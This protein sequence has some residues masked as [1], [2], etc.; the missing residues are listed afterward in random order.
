MLQSPPEKSTIVRSPKSLR[1]ARAALQAAYLVS[2]GLGVSL[3]ERMFTSPRRY[4]RPQREK[5]TLAT[6]RPFSVEV[7]LRSPR[8]GDRT[9]DVAAWRWGLGPTVLLVHGWEGRGSQLG[10]FVHPLVAAGMSVVAFDLP[11]HGDSPGGRTYLT[12]MAD[13]V[14]DVAASIGPIHATIAHSFGAAAVLLAHGRGHLDV[15][16]NVMIA[17]NALL[18]DSVRRFARFVGLDD[19][20]GAG[21]IAQLGASTGVPLATLAIDQLAAHRDA[22]LLVIHDRDDGEVPLAHGEALAATWPGARLRVTEGLGHRR[23][24]RDPDVIAEVVADLRR[25]VP[26]PPSDLVREVD[27]VLLVA[28]GLRPV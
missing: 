20:D 8:W 11:G 15:G 16:R 3:A 12:D 23:I 24:L 9:V 14:I 1:L 5:L 10:A 2:D 18:E 26:L 13:A 25:G 19:G 17:P 6:G 22:G 27:R 4:P 28:E 21:L 7:R